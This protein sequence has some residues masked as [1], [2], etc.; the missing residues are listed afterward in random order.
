[1]AAPLAASLLHC[2][3]DC[4]L[5]DNFES[6]SPV[7]RHSTV[8]VHSVVTALSGYV[9]AQYAWIASGLVICHVSSVICP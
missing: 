6:K 9:N 8:V 5:G 7:R 3:P 1:M 4:K 2:G